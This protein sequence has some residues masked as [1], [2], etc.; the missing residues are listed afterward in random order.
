[1]H[2]RNYYFEQQWTHNQELIIHPT[3]RPRRTQAA[4]VEDRDTTGQLMEER[5]VAYGQQRNEDLRVSDAWWKGATSEEQEILRQMR[6]KIKARLQ[7]HNEHPS[8]TSKPP[9]AQSQSSPLP[10]QYRSGK[11]AHLA[12]VDEDDD[13]DIEDSAVAHLGEIEG[14]MRSVF[15]GMVKST[16]PEHVRCNLDFCDRLALHSHSPMIAYATA[17]SGADTNVLGSEWRIVS[18]DPV[19]TVNLVGFVLRMPVREVCPSSPQIPLPRQLKGRKSSYDHTNRYQT[20]PH[21]QHYFLKY[22]SETQ[23]M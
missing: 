18:S 14:Q 6:L 1:M 23:G 10:Q 12:P 4:F 7:A 13:S 8:A 17:D 16:G 19:R 15:G 20:R 9:L 11:L 22:R 21:P 3:L 5:M 2:L